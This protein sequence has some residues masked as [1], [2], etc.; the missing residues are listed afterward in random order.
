MSCHNLS[1]TAYD[2]DGENNVPEPNSGTG[3]NVATDSIRVEDDQLA[4][5]D[6]DSA[7]GGSDNESAYSASVASSVFQHVYENGR[8]YHSYREGAYLNPD[9]E[10]EQDRLDLQHHIW[11]MLLNG[12]LYT[13]P[14]ANPL[15]ILD[16]GTGTGI[17]AMDIAEE[18][19]SARVKGTDISPIQPEW[20]PPNCHFYIDDV[21]SPWVFKDQFDYIH[22]RAMGGVIADWSKFHAE[23][24]KHLK[25]GGWLEFQDY[26]GHFSCD[27]KTMKD[28]SWMVQWT[29]EM[30][31][32]ATKFGK[33][34][35]VIG[36]QRRLMIDAGLINI[37]S[38]V[39]KVP[40][41]AWAKDKKLKEIGRY[42]EVMMLKSVDSY[43]PALYTRILGHSIAETQVVMEHVKQEVVDK[44]IHKY[45]NYHFV[46]GQKPPA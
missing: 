45:V 12:A 19:P 42:M 1:I 21:E 39:M 7:F 15:E 13:A 27:D 9:D 31:K 22:G 8:R 3:V 44:R 34:Y 41:G 30:G 5:D 11:K 6:A 10:D 37:R 46:C 26:E 4:I 23:C 2:M 36:K 17:W 28:N 20:V 16:I 29:E 25:P 38:Q 43:T 14:L 40:V 35:N 32:G 33:D 24:F 18:F